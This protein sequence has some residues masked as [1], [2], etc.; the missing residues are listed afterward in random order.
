V[1][2]VS[3]GAGLGRC[4]V[5]TARV[6]VVA[7]RIAGCGR[8]SEG[9][10][11]NFEVGCE[12]GCYARVG[13]CGCLVAGAWKAAVEE[14]SKGAGEEATACDSTADSGGYPRDDS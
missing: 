4:R 8:G 12:I 14:E 3:G 7:E 1:R 2:C 6:A 13:A 5:C 9:C 10:E 11:L